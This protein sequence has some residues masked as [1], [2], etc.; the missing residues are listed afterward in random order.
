MT[1]WTDTYCNPRE[2][3]AMHQYHPEKG[4]ALYNRSRDAV[5]GKSYGGMIWPRGFVGAAALWNWNSSVDS[6]SAE[7]IDAVW[8]TNDR[9]AKSGSLVCPSR[10]SCDQISACGKPYF[11]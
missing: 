9:L 11:A 7:F 8:S 5:Y 6:Q 2:C 10:C 4:S 1:A 3:G